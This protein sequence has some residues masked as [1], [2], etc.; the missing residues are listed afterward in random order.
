MTNVSIIGRLTADPEMKVTPSGTE[1][2]NITVA[3]NKGK[4]KCNFISCVA[5]K[6]NADF[7]CKYFHKG[8]WIGLSG[9][10]QTRTYQDNQG[11]NRKVTEVLVN[12]VD[13]VG[14]KEESNQTTPQATADIPYEE[15][16]LPF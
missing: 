8:S 6:N 1:F 13:F 5:F 10:L 16:D 7:I 4:D 9:E 14:G 15:E 2:L 12:R 3:D 11:N